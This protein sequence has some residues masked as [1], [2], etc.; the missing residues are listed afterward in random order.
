MFKEMK[1]T[2]FTIQIIFFFTLIRRYNITA[3]FLGYKT[4]T[5]QE[6]QVTNS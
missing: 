2:N 3:S 6:V 5:I 4:E 1:N